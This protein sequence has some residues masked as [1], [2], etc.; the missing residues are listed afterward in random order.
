MTF[1]MGAGIIRA[2]LGGDT[3]PVTAPDCFSGNC[4]WPD[5]TTLGVCSACKDAT[6]AEQNRIVHKDC[7]A[8]GEDPRECDLTLASGA[9]MQVWAGMNISTLYNMTSFENISYPIVN[10]TSLFQRI[11]DGGSDYG[12]APGLPL[13]VTECVMYF[14]WQTI[15]TSMTIGSLT[16]EVVATWQNES[17]PVLP[18]MPYPTAVPN[19]TSST[20][21]A[22]LQNGLIDLFT[23]VEEDQMAEAGRPIYGALG[24]YTDEQ[25]IGNTKTVQVIYQAQSGTVPVESAWGD[26][27]NFNTSN[28]TVPSIGLG[29]L[30]QNIS[31]S[32]T[33]LIR[34]ADST[35]APVIGKVWT[36]ETIV[37]VQWIWFIYP[38]AMILLTLVFLVATIVQSSSQDIKVWK[39]SILAVLFHGLDDPGYNGTHQPLDSTDMERRAEDVKVEFMPLASAWRFVKW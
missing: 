32:M 35:T 18:A 16:E 31:I 3:A 11:N 9:L 15:R 6:S 39:S 25:G 27:E 17:L 37:H 33:N 10:I 21:F 13:F 5:F 28:K 29:N 2:L 19:G 4:T 34:N 22:G 30:L 36:A 14:C 1:D 38:I 24:P 12:G 23:A 8:S 7:S 20:I 26:V